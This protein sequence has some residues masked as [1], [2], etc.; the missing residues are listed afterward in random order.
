ML[1]DILSKTDYNSY[2]IDAEDRFGK[3]G[4]IGFAVILRDTPARVV[5]LAFSCRVQSKRLE[6]AVLISLMNKHSAMGAR[7]MEVFYRATDKNAQVGQVFGDLGFVIAS[8]VGQDFVYS[9]DFSEGMPENEFVK[10]NFKRGE[11]EY[12][13]C[14]GYPA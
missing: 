2:L 14:T 8:Q 10:V 4:S 13:V 9:F 12:L 3:Y 7:A 11:E 5:D 1:A 6:H